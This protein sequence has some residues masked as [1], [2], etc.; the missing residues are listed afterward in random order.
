[1][2][3]LQVNYIEAAVIFLNEVYGRPNQWRDYIY[4]DH[5]YQG[6]HSEVVAKTLYPTSWK[7]WIT[8][9]GSQVRPEDFQETQKAQL[10]IDTINRLLDPR[11]DTILLDRGTKSR[12]LTAREKRI[13]RLRTGLETGLLYT[14]REI[15]NQFSVSTNRALTLYESAGHKIRILH[16][17]KDLYQFLRQ[18]PLINRWRV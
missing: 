8:P 13:L 7:D 10:L 17:F 12:I 14:F 5:L 6:H 15:G 1:M 16:D 18:P 11:K 3:R 4:R 9:N 2:E